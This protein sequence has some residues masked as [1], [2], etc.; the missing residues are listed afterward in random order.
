[1][2]IAGLF[3]FIVRIESYNLNPDT[4]QSTSITQIYNTIDNTFRT[5]LSQGKSSQVEYS[6]AKSKTYLYNV[7]IQCNLK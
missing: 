4:T 3:Y 1:M 5:I 7:H 2:F 6:P